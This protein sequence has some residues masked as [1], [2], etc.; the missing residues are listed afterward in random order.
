MHGMECTSTFLHDPALM[1]G[2]AALVFV[3][4]SM[5][6]LTGTMKGSLLSAVTGL[7]PAVELL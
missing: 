5:E 1:L 6:L 4:G 3:S 2:R 7:E